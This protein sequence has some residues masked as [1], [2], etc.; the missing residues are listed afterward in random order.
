MRAFNLMFVVLLVFAFCASVAH[1]EWGHLTGRFVYD[2]PAPQTRYLSTGGKDQAVCGEK[3]IDESL[4]V[5]AED[6]WC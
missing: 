1:A 4:L 2:G 3:V 5:D 6:R